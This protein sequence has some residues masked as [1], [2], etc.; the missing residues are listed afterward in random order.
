MDGKGV[1]INNSMMQDLEL[2]L[3]ILKTMI[4]KSN[5]QEITA[6]VTDLNNWLCKDLEWKTPSEFF[7]VS[8]P[9]K[10]DNLS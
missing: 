1:F 4:I 6:S 5:D 10:L 8:E 3:P 9:L 7:S 2:L